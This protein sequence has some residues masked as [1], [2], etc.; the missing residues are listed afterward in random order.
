VGVALQTL[1]LAL[2]YFLF[3]I[4]PERGMARRWISRGL[5]IGVSLYFL[6]WTWV[7]LSLTTSLAVP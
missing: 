6:A 7:M 4:S 3:W 2:V 1:F 5:M